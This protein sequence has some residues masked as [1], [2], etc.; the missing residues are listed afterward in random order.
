MI[1]VSGHGRL[2]ENRSHGTRRPRS[3]RDSRHIFGL[4][5]SF[6]CGSAWS[7]WPSPSAASGLS[8]LAVGA[9]CGGRS[10]Y[11]ILPWGIDHGQEMAKRLGLAQHGIPTDGMMSPDGYRDCGGWIYR[12]MKQRCHVG[13]IRAGRCWTPAANRRRSA[14]TGIQRRGS[15]AGDRARGKKRSAGR[16]QLSTIS[17]WWG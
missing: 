3:G 1:G 2:A 10:I 13:F 9:L 17:D 15:D 11:A 12:P 4:G 5:L 16:D 7:A 14:A 6:S 8:M